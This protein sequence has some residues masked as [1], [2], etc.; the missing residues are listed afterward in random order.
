MEIH[1]FKDNNFA[2]SGFAFMV[3]LSGTAFINDDI[4]SP[5]IKKNNNFMLLN[6]FLI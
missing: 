3:N 2:E 1:E 6:L 5:S 4:L